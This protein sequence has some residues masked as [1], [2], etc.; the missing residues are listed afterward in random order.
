[1]KTKNINQPL[2][3]ICTIML[4]TM[5]GCRKFLDIGSPVTETSSKEIFANDN[6]ATSAML[7]VYGEFMK[8]ANLS[9]GASM[10]LGQSADELRSYASPPYSNYYTNNLDPVDNNDFWSA[11]Y[12]S[13]YRCNAVL[14]GVRGSAALS[15]PVKD[16]LI[17]EALF[18]R[19]FLHFY[20]VN[21]FGDVP[22]IAT[23]DYQQNNLAPREARQRVYE[24]I[25]TDLLQARSLL[26]DAFPD[27]ANKP[28]LER[29]RPNRTA[30]EAM[31]SRVY[32]YE[33]NWEKAEALASAVLAKTQLY[34]L[35]ADLN[36]VFKKNSKE[37]IWQ[38][39][40]SDPT[41]TNG[42]EGSTYILIAPPGAIGKFSLAISDQLS[43]AFE[44]ADKRK[45]AWTG[46]FLTFRYPYKYKI[47]ALSQ[48]TTEYSMV[49]RLAELYL[50]RSEARAMQGKLQ[51]S[52][53]DLDMIRFR[54][55]LS[56]IADTNPAVNQQALL[57]LI[58]HERQ[59]EL[60]TEWGHRWLDLK[61]TG[62][63]E[64]VLSPLK[65]QN[66]Q[67]TDQLYP[68]PKSQ[69]DYSPAYQGAQNP[70]YN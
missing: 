43:S 2:F 55:G 37:A 58:W 17:G 70:G 68:I 52:I 22:Y 60:F 7:G 1:M 65:G 56:K 54:A 67:A 61:R 23:T 27:A 39:M 35:N 10:F 4:I 9:I 45:T 38:M 8:T 18:M 59:V 48:P 50:I 15:A 53:S 34:Q 47:S 41:N 62:R 69:I 24:K 32:L 49:I 14:Q 21:L 46:S 6:S 11:Y 25:I 64:A 36:E 57:E 16:Q 44:N 33:K 12:S 19:A 13:I 66:W 3:V 31:L 42:F 28:S 40:P 20:L 29:V 51:E 30:A 5:C 63:A 26:T